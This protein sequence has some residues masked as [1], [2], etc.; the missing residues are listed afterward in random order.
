MPLR[1]D[2]VTIM[3]VDDNPHMRA[4]LRDIL[5]GF[6][7]QNIVE[8]SDGS[9]AFAELQ[10]R[11]AD[12]VF[13][14]WM[15]ASLDGLAFTRLV[16]A[17][18]DSPNPFLPIV[19]LTGHTERRRILEARDAGA[20]EFLAKP[21]TPL[22][23][24]SRIRAVIETPRPFVRVGDYVGP[25]RRRKLEDFSGEERRERARRLPRTT[26]QERDD[27]AGLHAVAHEI[28]EL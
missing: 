12:L 23:L 5:Q 1:L 17:A 28:G 27:R 24:Y 8:C 4:L 11:P 9:E 26:A 7:V 20:T 19:M 3:L 14:D 15:M 6:E 13:V 25:C 10:H 18:P 16:R 21:V 22:G 2:R